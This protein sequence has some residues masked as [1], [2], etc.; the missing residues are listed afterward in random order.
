VQEEN[1]MLS[2]NT[3][4]V[5]GGVALLIDERVGMEHWWDDG[6]R[7]EPSTVVGDNPVTAFL[8]LPQSPCG[9]AWDQTQASMVRGW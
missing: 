9:L 2:D 8:C 3:V 6:D 4:S 1:L 7:V 5:C